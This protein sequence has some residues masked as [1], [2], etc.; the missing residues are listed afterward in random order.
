MP[1]SRKHTEEGHEPEAHGEVARLAEAHRAGGLQSE[2]VKLGRI[3]LII[4]DEV[5]YI[6][7]EAET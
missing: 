5:G 4:V 1:E 2:L 6:P 7:F 3:P